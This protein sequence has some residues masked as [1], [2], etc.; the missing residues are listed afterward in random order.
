[1]SNAVLGILT[2]AM[3]AAAAGDSLAQR[4]QPP[5]DRSAGETP[6][7]LRSAGRLNIGDAAPD[8]TLGYKGSDDT[9]TLSELKGDKPVALVFGS[10]T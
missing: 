2:L 7:S 6:R 1:M 9:F 3:L 10:Y 4:R 5:R 8:F